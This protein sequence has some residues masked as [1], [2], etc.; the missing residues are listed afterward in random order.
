[1]RIFSSV[2]MTLGVA[3]VLATLTTGQEPRRPGGFQ[4][5]GSDPGQILK[6]ENVQKELKITEEQ[7]K[8]YEELQKKALADALSP[9]QL[10]RL[11]QIQLQQ[12]GLRAFQDPEVQTAL[13]MTD[14]QKEKVKTIAED[15]DKDRREL[16]KG[17]VG[18]GGNREEM[19]KKITAYNK[20]VMDKTTAVLSEDQKKTWKDMVGEPFEGLRQGFGFPGRTGANPKKGKNKTQQ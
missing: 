11:K 19:M 7:L 15:S 2:V 9:E 4:G 12:R 3:I 17:A 13:K 10:K 18:G 8:K 6:N 5:P 16:F 1:M 14:D 20:E